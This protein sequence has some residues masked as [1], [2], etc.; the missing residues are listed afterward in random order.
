MKVALLSLN[1]A[2]TDKE[3]LERIRELVSSA[4][5][6]GALLCVLP[7]MCFGGYNAIPKEC[8]YGADEFFALLAKE[9]NVAI[10]YGHVK[11]SNKKLKN[12]LT[13]VSNSGKKL[14]SYDKMHV[15]TFA[16]EQKSFE[17]GDALASFSIDGM[18]FG[19]SVCYDLRFAELY[20]LYAKSCDAVLCIAAWPKKRIST[21]KLLL[22]ARAVENV[23][24]LV[25][26]NWQGGE[27]V[28]SSRVAN[29]KGVF[30][31][32]V[33]ASN[34]LDIYEITPSAKDNK[35]PNSVND[36]RYELYAKLYAKEAKC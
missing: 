13:V 5:S 8:D 9:A 10:A 35:T 2:L 23:T 30:A 31:K 3:R 32:P 16:N 22:K 27:Y 4:S 21:F 33:F 28:K 19:L 17:G 26:V 24:T 29:Q 1:V 15:F 7:E 25:G 11:N 12:S 14:A 6:I 18:R 20:S 36:K 34:E